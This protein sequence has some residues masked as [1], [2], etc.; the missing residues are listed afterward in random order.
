[1]DGVVEDDEQAGAEAEATC[2]GVTDAPNLV[3][4]IDPDGIEPLVEG[5][6]PMVDWTAETAVT[7]CEVSTMGYVSCK[8][9][10]WSYRPVIGR[11][12]CWPADAPSHK[13]SIQSSCYMHASCRTPA[14]MRKQVSEEFLVRW[15]L[16]GIVEPDASQAR[17]RELGRLHVQ[18]F[19][20]MLAQQS[21][22]GEFGG[23]GSVSSGLVQP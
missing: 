16:S 8:V 14:K 5:G 4:E 1:M 19:K 21:S 6:S 13:Q 20:D 10:P 11:V 22:A 12:T 2:E 23:A 18:T 7:Q 3:D 17:R 9:S 15:L